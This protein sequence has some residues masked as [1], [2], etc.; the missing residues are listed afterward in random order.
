MQLK[1]YKKI[2]AFSLLVSFVMISSGCGGEK[3]ESII[4]ESVEKLYNSNAYT[5]VN[6]GEDQYIYMLYNK[7]KEVIAESHDSA[8]AVY[9]KDDV[10]VG[11]ADKVY[12]MNDITPLKTIEYALDLV[13]NGKAEIKSEPKEVEESFDGKLF[14]IYVRG[15]DNIKSLYEHVSEEY[16]LEMVDLLYD[17]VIEEEDKDND[18]SYLDIVYS[19][20]NNGAVG[21]ECA[22]VH[23]ED[24]KY[25]TW[26]FDGYLALMGWELPSSWYENSLTDEEESQDKWIKMVG[27]LLDEMDIKMQK[28]AEQHGLTKDNSEDTDST[29]ESSIEKSNESGS[30]DFKEMEG[31]GDVNKDDVYGDIKL[32]DDNK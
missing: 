12:M 2:L 5:Q 24:E 21:A 30:L 18:N 22:I 11:F 1:K 19:I 29:S 32:E 9:R 4:R 31:T 17:G 16:A 23:S 25:T 6:V 28:Y 26:W 10:I 15:R 7:N 27:S 3:P 20:A 8:L 13:E 14:H